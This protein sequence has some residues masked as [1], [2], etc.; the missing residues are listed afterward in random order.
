MNV[1]YVEVI[2][3]ITVY[4]QICMQWHSQGREW[5]GTGPTNHVRYPTNNHESIYIS[6]HT[7][8]FSDKTIHHNA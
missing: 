1:K 7:Y 3:T 5:L 8:T 2:V 6:F 4:H